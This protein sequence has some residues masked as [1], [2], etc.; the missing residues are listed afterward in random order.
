MWTEWP[1]ATQPNLRRGRLVALQRAEELAVLQGAEF[2]LQ[3]GSR[4]EEGAVHP[5]LVGVLPIAMVVVVEIAFEPLLRL[6]SV[7]SLS[8]VQR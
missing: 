6:P 4:L 5:A 8:S 1:G 3:V 2:L 7:Q